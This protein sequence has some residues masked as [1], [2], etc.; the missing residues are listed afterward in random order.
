MVALP[1]DGLMALARLMRLIGGGTFLVRLGLLR[2]D[3]IVPC[4]SARLYY[5]RDLLQY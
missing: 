3:A 5:P 4:V 1:I 2:E